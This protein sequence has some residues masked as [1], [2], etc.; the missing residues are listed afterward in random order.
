M[1][2][3]VTRP[4][5]PGIVE[6]Q[7][8]DFFLVFGN[9]EH[10]I[11]APRNQ[12]CRTFQKR[13]RRRRRRKKE[14]LEHV[15]HSSDLIFQGILMRRAYQAVK[16]GDWEHDLEVSVLQTLGLADVFHPV[17][18]SLALLVL[19]SVHLRVRVTAPPCSHQRKCPQTVSVG[20]IA[21]FIWS[22]Q[23]TKY[24]WSTCCLLHPREGP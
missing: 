23:F 16:S 6:L 20:C 13:N 14:E 9:C 15:R 17:I 8:V 12:A 1:I 19:Q 24:K 18:D 5:F 11:F 2:L 4:F 22:T 21:F 3:F 10:R 7:D